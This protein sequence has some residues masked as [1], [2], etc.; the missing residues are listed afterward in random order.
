M[1]NILMIGC[2]H[3]G[4]ALLKKWTESKSNKITVIDPIK[5][6]KIKKKYKKT[7][8]IVFKKV[9]NKIDTKKFDIVVLAVKPQIVSKVLKDYNLLYFKKTCVL[10]SIIAGKKIS[11]FQKN[12][13]NISQI[14]RVM[15]NMP[16][17]I[18]EGVS[19]ITSN[20]NVTKF[21]K[22]LVQKLFSKVGIVVWLNNEKEIDIST[23]ISGSGPGYIFY[24]VDAIEKASNKL[25]LNKNIN[26][27]IVLQTFLGSLKLLMNSKNTAK[28]LADKIAI[29]GGTTEAG[30]KLMKDKNLE[31]IIVLALRSAHQRA[32]I[33]SK[34]Q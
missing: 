8:V 20:K 30:I 17:L 14:I 24:L 12:I 25:G 3:M 16:A 26:N 9:N 2:G 11:F 6:N 21:N 23:A 32:K 18:G 22:N 19:C 10:I 5:C 34:I 13:P 15:P 4:S 28:E 33:L 31:K 7:K 1:N 27:K 29:K